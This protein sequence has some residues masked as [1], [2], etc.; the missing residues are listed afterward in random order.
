MTSRSLLL[1][2]V[3]ILVASF[4]TESHAQPV[5]SVDIC[6]YGGTSAG[7]IA[8]YSAKRL[9]HSAL[10]IEPCGQVGGMTTSGLGE[11]D[12]GNKDAIT[13]LARDFYRRVGAYY[14][15][16]ESWTFE[17]HVATAVFQ[18]YIRATKLPVW[19]HYRLNRVEKKGQPLP[20]SCSSGPAPEQGPDSGKCGPGS[21]STVP[22]KAT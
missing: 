4:S 14:S 5:T 7:V 8:A 2:F 21:S 20:P 10:L 15:K 11:T 22:M 3:V 9:G 13:G 1:A 12:I 16:T 18:D 17:P 6:V 19:Y